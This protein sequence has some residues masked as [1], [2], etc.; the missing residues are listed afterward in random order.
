MKKKIILISIFIAIVIASMFYGKKWF[1][2]NSKVEES[3]IDIFEGASV[4][5]VTDLL[6][7]SGSIKN[8]EILFYYI[9]AKQLYYDLAPWVN[10][11]FDVSFK[12]GKFQIDD[13]DF[14]SLI[15]TLNEAKNI[16]ED[17]S[18]FI[19]IPEGSTVEQFATIISEKGIFKKENFIK[20]TND[21]TFY[22]S[23]RDKYIWLPE[24]NEKKINQLEGYLQANTYDI[25]SKSKPHEVIRTMLDQTNKWYVD[26]KIEITKSNY[27]FDE[28]L[29]LASIVER[30]SKF[31]E[32][33]PK[34]AQVFYNR[35]KNNMKLESDITASYANEEHKVFMTYEDVATNSPFNTYVIEGLPLGPINSPSFSSFLATLKPEGSGFNH[36]FFYAR[37]SGETFYSESYDEHNKVRIKYE[38]EWLELVE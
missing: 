5:Q 20:L 32:D 17:K 3:T 13:G 14:D 35:L 16:K 23:L 30:E 1:E 21:R 2:N 25:T 15:N 33:R 18:S 4:K 24:Y 6:E 7:L 38:N 31:E 10:A 28:L 29:T 37:P 22:N 9:R 34:V 36:L 19:V 27:T 11:T 26:N 8:S 12:P